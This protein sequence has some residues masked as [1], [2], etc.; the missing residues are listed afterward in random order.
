[1]YISLPGRLQYINFLMKRKIPAGNMFISVKWLFVQ[2]IYMFN[3]SSSSAECEIV[4][5]TS[6]LC[7]TFTT[8]HNVYFVIGDITDHYNHH[9]ETRSWNEVAQLCQKIKGYL[10]SFTSRDE[11]NDFIFLLRHSSYIPLMEGIF[12]GLKHNINGVSK[13]LLTNNT[14][15][16]FF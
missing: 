3:F 6:E 13:Y 5:N 2:R 4:V 11:L 1:M 12:I 16:I 15:F 10:P 9:R 14:T 8:K 7:L